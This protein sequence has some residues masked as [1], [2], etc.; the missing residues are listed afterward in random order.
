VAAGS[1][2]LGTLYPLIVDAL[3]M[4]KLSVGPPYFNRVFVPLM[5]PAMFLMG[6]GPIARWKKAS[7]PELAVRLRWAFL[8]SLVAGLLL[9]FVLGQWKP[10]VALGLLLAL[11]IVATAVLNLWERVKITSGQLTVWQ[12]LRMQ[13]RSY[14]GMHLAHIGVAA[15]IVGVTLVTGYESEKDVRMTAGDTVTVGGYIFRLNSVREVQ[16]PN[17]VAAR[18][19]VEVIKNSESIEKMYPEKRSYLASGNAM[20]ETAI[21]TGLFRDLYV[22]LGEPLGDGAWSV[23]VYYKPFVDWIWGGAVL[24]ALGGGLALSDRRYLLAA[25]KERQVKTI[26]GTEDSVPSLAA[27]SVQAEP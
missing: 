5:V 2:L 20:T 24:M 10:L 7:L 18:G 14:Y 23:R 9:P 1:V 16:G 27:A 4:G 17:Y 26:A 13:T 19:E 22:S 12:K 21:N 8:A 3:G 15:F 25:R 11:W 6:I